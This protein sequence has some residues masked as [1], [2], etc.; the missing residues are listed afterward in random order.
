M[1]L[2][3]LPLILSLC[4]VLQLA[5]AQTHFQ[6]FDQLTTQSGLVNNVVNDIVQDANGYLWFATWG[7][8]QRYDGKN[9][10]TFR[11]KANDS[12]S[13]PADAVFRLLV[14]S[15]NRLWVVTA[16]GA[17]IFQ[18][19]TRTFESI[20][21]PPAPRGWEGTSSLFE[22]SRGTIWI[23][24]ALMGL[25][26]C[27]HPAKGFLPYF[28]KWKNT[29]I[30]GITCM[31][32]D[33]RNGGYW[34]GAKN[35]LFYFDR[36]SQVTKEVRLHPKRKKRQ[37]IQR[38]H[39]DQFGSLWITEGGS[40]THY[41][42]SHDTVQWGTPATGLQCMIS[43][44]NGNR[45]ALGSKVQKYDSLQRQWEDYVDLNSLQFSQPGQAYQ[46][47]S[48]YEDRDGAIWVGSN[49]G[50]FVFMPGVEKFQYYPIPSQVSEC[51]GTD[52]LSR[53]RSTILQTRDSSLIVLSTKGCERGVAIFDKKMRLTQKFKPVMKR[54]QNG[55]SPPVLLEDSQ[56]TIWY[57]CDSG[58]IGSFQ[59]NGRMI[60]EQSSP[61]FKNAV[62]LSATEDHQKN[63]YWA[64][65]EQT[66]VKWHRQTNRFERILNLQFFKEFED[67]PLLLIEFDRTRNCLWIITSAQVICFHNSSNVKFSKANRYR[68]ITDVKSW[69]DAHFIIGSTNGLFLLEKDSLNTFLPMVVDGHPFDY[70][71]T[72]LAKDA[73]NN[74]WVGTQ[75]NGLFKVLNTRNKAIE[76]GRNDGVVFSSAFAGMAL[77]KSGSLAAS[78]PNGL[79]VIDPSAA[80][81]AQANPR[82]A[83]TSITI[84]DA[85]INLDS[86]EFLP[87]QLSWKQNSIGI[88]FSSLSYY[89]SGK[90]NYQ[91]RLEGTGSQWSFSKGLEKIR[92]TELPPGTYTFRVRS[93]PLASDVISDEASF[94]FEIAT[95]FWST[96]SFRLSVGLAVSLL[97]FYIYYAKIQRVLLIQKIRNRISSD[98]HDHIGSSLSSISIMLNVVSSSVPAGQATELLK[99]IANTAH[100][101]QEN[102]YDIVWSINSKN[103]SM[104]QIVARMKEFMESIFEGQ[105]TQLTFFVAESIKNEDL[106]LDKRYDLY[107]IFKEMV[108]NGAKYARASHVNVA[109]Q[110]L[111]S[112][113]EVTYEDDGVG[114]D[115][116]V[117]TE[118]NGVLNMKQRSLNMGG[119]FHLT[120]AP[121]K[122][123][124]IVVRFPV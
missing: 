9:Y 123:T 99:K 120:S 117:E 50:V 43:S 121:G 4:L 29:S 48:I 28:Q 49:N 64:T 74:I 22:D 73:L 75:G 68:V 54:L 55:S 124:R 116:T 12:T 47:R 35:G 85:E 102:L 5:L 81:N 3:W 114:F 51:G 72:S 14:D 1:R 13:L 86:A 56:G 62:L 100:L 69:D 87:H 89:Y 118:G 21:L 61:E 34:I 122:G 37:S 16:N 76:F 103:S 40:T 30:D 106:R 45:W 110:R 10:L 104:T 80:T 66:I 58:T 91:Y 96:W 39:A 36:Q 95:P 44:T 70:H 46:L 6:Q 78:I 38:L 41:R 26:Y 8:L 109:I 94:S 11:S 23:S 115:S 2:S 17:A 77:L 53:F 108:N 60:S 111:K 97:I 7:G 79:L 57:S 33:R 93:Q 63:I 67:S 59:S 71:V 15:K 112:E 25:Y 32:E 24:D 105:E 18:R 101:T 19:A 107:L 83:I 119:T 113:I 31:E 42:M 27:D 90:V 88:E 65:S 98:L 20:H 82:V 84:N 52:S 92:Y